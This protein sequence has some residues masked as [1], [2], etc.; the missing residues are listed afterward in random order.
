MLIVSWDNYYYNVFLREIYW[1]VY[2][3][4]FYNNC[5]LLE[6]YLTKNRAKYYQIEVMTMLMVIT[7]FYV[8]TCQK[9]FIIRNISFSCKNIKTKHTTPYRLWALKTSLKYISISHHSDCMRDCE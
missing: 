1:S 5:N 6:K 7:L 9:I 8:P 4:K 2:G 3:V